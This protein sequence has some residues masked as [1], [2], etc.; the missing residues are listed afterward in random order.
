M[1]NCLISKLN[2]L[3]KKYRFD[4]KILIVP[5]FNTGHQILQDLSRNSEGWINF[6][7]ATVESLASE[8][9]AE[10][11]LKDG[12]EKISSIESNFIIDGIFTG[13]A[14]EGSLA[15]FEKYT[16]NTGI[17]NTITDIIIELK[18]SGL[19]H[20]D[21]KKEHFIDPKKGE[22]L[23]LIFS[24]Y[25]DFLKEKGLADTGDIIAASCRILKGSGPPD[26][27]IKYIVLSRYA[28]TPLEK[29][30]IKAIS[31][32]GPIV[33]AE[34]EIYGI[35]APKNRWE[36]KGSS[37]RIDPASNIERAGWLFD[38]AGAP[39]PVVDNSISLFSAA[40]CQSEIYE[41]LGRIT[42]EKIP[43]D[44]VEIIY[45]NSDPYLLSLYNICTKLNLPASFSE[46]LPGDTSLPGMALKGFLLWI[47][48][49]YATVH[50]RKLLSC[51]LIKTPK[52]AGP[53]LAHILRTSKV[54][55]GRNRYSPVLNKEIAA[56]KDKIKE[57]GGD[58]YKRRLDDYKALAAITGKL[59]EMVPPPDSSGRVD[60]AGL[61]S[62]CLQFLNDF[63]IP[64]DED[65]VP[66][67][68]NLKQRLEVL[69]R[70]TGREVTFEEAAGKLLEVISRLPYKKSGPKPGCL[71]ISNLA[72]GGRSGR[73][74]TYITGMDS[75]KF[76]GTQ[77][78]D[79]VLLDEERQK[80]DSG[81]RL[82][83]DRLK[84][85]LYDFTSMIAGLRGR[86]AVS[87]SR[88][89]IA[90][91]RAMFP[92]SVY[93]QVYRLKEGDSSIDYQSLLSGPAGPSGSG[94]AKIIDG[95]GWWVDRLTGSGAI[96][97]ARGSIF[98]I[99]PLLGR[100]S[101]AMGQR[102]GSELTVYDGYIDPIG[103]ELDPRENSALALSCSAIETYAGNPY[104][105][106]LEY[107]LGARRPQEIER[108][109]FR[110]LDLAQRGSLLHEVFQ[111][112][113]RAVMDGGEGPD[114]PEQ[115]K[116]INKILDEVLERYSEDVPV[117][118]PSVKTREVEVLRRDLEVFLDINSK[119]ARPHLTE[120]EFGYGGKEPVKICT[121]KESYIHIKGKVDRIDIDSGG[122]YHVWDYKTGSAYAYERSGYIAGGR[123]V[124]HI[125]YAKAVEVTTGTVVRCGY[126]LPT[127]RGI[128]SG[129]GIIFERDPHRDESWQPAIN[130]IMD[131]MAGGLFIISDE[132]NPPY[133]DDSDIYGTPELKKSIK[134]KIKESGSELLSKWK[135]LKDYK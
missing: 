112:F 93:L 135:S 126:L 110:W 36:E 59:I 63:I 21:L 52:G 71:Y 70:I 5:D 72:S 38:V 6:K 9:A 53:R 103:T 49:D 125:L 111:L 51:S 23:R 128:S 78:Q 32:G 4:E 120:F 35:G 14:E 130:S 50:L 66:Y 134:S 25:Q 88:Y 26:S 40:T 108:N 13:L 116:I 22:D 41:L 86:A 3:I 19:S 133:L 101:Y 123:Q 33:I 81:I 122:N 90:D 12:T 60:F 106:F 105:Y 83:E 57:G 89:D 27:S 7:A 95:T 104:T 64:K 62:G 45:T 2:Q 20:Q 91:E 75:H 56:I 10:K 117:P 17:I 98:N 100:G 67:L 18:M 28:N 37:N 42:A 114:R 48:D 43:L 73:A 54:G 109:R 46:G 80:I 115:S 92:S 61:C 107:I 39:R 124:Q 11:L 82:S 79:P 74:N 85:K 84:E 58:N 121:G 94:Q 118:A 55:W 102:L 47:N 24:G 129:K 131:L 97:D 44:K 1:R 69:A 30:F 87:Y 16:I 132:E 31:G 15:Y 99:Y 8:I 65:S 127:E 96:K 34:E 113:I 119:L 68:S 76:P 29:K 77:I